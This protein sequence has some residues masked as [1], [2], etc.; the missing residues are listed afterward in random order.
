MTKIEKI[1]VTVSAVLAP[2]IAL[3]FV[4]ML[5]WLLFLFAELIDSFFI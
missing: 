5:F 3:C 1:L 2:A 4:F